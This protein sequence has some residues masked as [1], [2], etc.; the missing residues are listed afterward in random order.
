MD[1]TGYGI[2]RIFGEERNMKNIM[3][4]EGVRESESICRGTHRLYDLEW[5]KV[6]VVKL[7]LRAQGSDV[8]TEKP[9]QLALL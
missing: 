8:H 5:A 9:H 7:T 1:A 3:D 2:G 6:A 4:L